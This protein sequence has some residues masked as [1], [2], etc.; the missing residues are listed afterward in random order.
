MLRDGGS[1]GTSLTTTAHLLTV[2]TPSEAVDGLDSSERSLSH[3]CLGLEAVRPFPLSHGA[4]R[5]PTMALGI[6]Q[7][8]GDAESGFG[9]ELGAGIHWRS[10]ER[11]ISG[12][13]KGHTLLTHREENFQEQVPALS[14]SWEPSPSNRETSPSP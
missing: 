8:D 11:G 1:G 13:L 5:L 12:E 6:R 2:K 4:S 14:F 10:P 9:L 7:D 3:L